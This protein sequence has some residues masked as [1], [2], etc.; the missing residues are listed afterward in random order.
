MIPS[1]LVAA[2]TT[3]SA[4][5]SAP[6]SQVL[7]LQHALAAS[8]LAASGQPPFLAG[9]G[10]GRGF[11]QPHRPF[12]KLCYKAKKGRS[13]YLF[14]PT[15]DLRC[16]SKI[17]LSTIKL[18]LDEVNSYGDY[19]LPMQEV[20]EQVTDYQP[21]HCLHCIYS[22]QLNHIQSM[23]AQILLVKDT[24]G[25]LLF[26]ELDSAATYSYITLNEC[27]K[28]GLNINPNNHHP[29]WVTEWL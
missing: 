24:V 8:I 3:A 19:V 13:T 29:N 12:C 10:W 4:N 5:P 27:N 2:S 9:W 17:Q 14:H 7:C 23:P 18:Y 1:N 22:G 28:K 26:L 11:S 6:A 20:K 25:A 15:A 21:Q 16:P